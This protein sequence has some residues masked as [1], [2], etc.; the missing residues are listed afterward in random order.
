[1]ITS[2]Q[3]PAWF[4]VFVDMYLPELEKQG[5]LVVATFDETTWQ[6]DDDSVPNNDNSIVTMVTMVTMLFGAGA[7]LNTKDDTIHDALRTASRCRD[8][9]WSWLSRME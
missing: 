2:Q 4:N 3:R 5:V 1:M 7:T 8:E 6:N 9:F